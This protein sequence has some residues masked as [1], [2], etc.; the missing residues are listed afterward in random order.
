MKQQFKDLLACYGNSLAAFSQVCPC[1]KLAKSVRNDYFMVAIIKVLV[2]QNL[3][4]Y[5]SACQEISIILR[6]Y[7]SSNGR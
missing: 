6:Y 3:P 7:F 1:I 4:Q 5:I 2:A